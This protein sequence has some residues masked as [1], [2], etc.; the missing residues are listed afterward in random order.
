ML[1]DH[2][3]CLVEVFFDEE[4]CVAVAVV[5]GAFSFCAVRFWIYVIDSNGVQFIEIYVDGGLHFDVSSGGAG[6]GW[7]SLCVVADLLVVFAGGIF[8]VLS[9][10]VVFDFE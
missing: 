8:F 1:F 9:E 4:P 3:E 6:G 7:F 2:G 5:I 10:G